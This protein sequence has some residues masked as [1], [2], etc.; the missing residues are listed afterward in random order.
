[1]RVIVQK[2]GGSSLSNL[3][4]IRSIA[5]KIA[6]SHSEKTAIVVVVSAMGD[7]T[8]NLLDM[9]RQLSKSPPKRE[10][11][12]LLT[13]GER[14][15]M[16]L[17][18]IALSD[19]GVPAISFTGSQSGI[20]TDNTH[21]SARIVDIRPDRIVQELQSGKVV[22][23][24]GFQG[25]SGRRNVTTLGRG[26]SDTT[27]V[28]LS[29]ALGVDRCEIYTDVAGLYTA[30]PNIVP[31][32]KRVTELS[33]KIALDIRPQVIDFRSVELA[34]RKHIEVFIRS[35]H[36]G[37]SETI[38]QG[39]NNMEEPRIKGISA[40]RG[41]TIFEGEMPIDEI[42]AILKW[43]AERRI[44]LMKPTIIT[45]GEIAS[46]RFYT[47]NE[48]SDAIVSSKWDK[49][50]SKRDGM[51]LVHIAGYGIADDPYIL[52]ELVNAAN[53]LTK[54]EGIIPLTTGY[55]ILALDKDTDVL[56]R[57]LHR[58]FVR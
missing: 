28:A 37:K 39:D 42:A 1:M 40:T 20:I 24:G 5:Q 46:I 21:T 22:I 2:Y 52:S 18:A 53:A 50:L 44:A 19:I 55:S 30:D 43:F 3:E 29:A 15:S 11:D 10:I 47:L 8:D 58:R 36:G 26:G 23:V 57:E 27:A 31:E 32:T 49:V 51:A 7:T 35:A 12:M 25:V 13:S 41:V 4:Q 45:G 6:L 17:L 54:I 33:Y 48:N 9:A 56:V 14:I 34:R 38:I 16:T